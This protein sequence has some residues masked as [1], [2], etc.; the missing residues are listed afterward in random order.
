MRKG[1]LLILLMLPLIFAASCERTNPDKEIFQDTVAQFS[2]A[3]NNHDSKAMADFWATDGTLLS[4]WT[5]SVYSG[6]DEIEKYFVREQ[7]DGMKDSQ[8]KLDIE[9]VRFID[10]DTAFVDAN[11]TI[12]GMKIAGENAV[13]FRNHGVFLFVKRDGK[14][15]I[16]EARPY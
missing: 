1:I 10:S 11:L 13:P 14:W 3:W 2:S 15:K 8:I 7:I 5:N 16:L 9:K 6:R 4:P 12:S